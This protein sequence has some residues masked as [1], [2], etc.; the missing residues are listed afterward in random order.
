MPPLP[1]AV[2]LLVLGVALAFVTDPLD[3]EWLDTLVALQ[4]VVSALVTAVLLTVW[5]VRRLRQGFQAASAAKLQ[6]SAARAER[7]RPTPYRFNPPPAWPTPAPHWVPAP[8]WEPER[9]WP[10]IPRGWQLWERTSPRPAPPQRLSAWDP[11]PAAERLVD[12]H[13]QPDK[14]RNALNSDGGR[15]SLQIGAMQLQ[16]GGL[17]QRIHIDIEH[18]PGG[19][20]AAERSRWHPLEWAYRH[21]CDAVVGIAGAL[22]DELSAANE[23]DSTVMVG[24]EHI[25]RWQHLYSWMDEALDAAA[26]RAGVSRDDP[27]LRNATGAAPSERLSVSVDVGATGWQEAERLAASALRQFGFSDADVT[28]AGTDRGLDVSGSSIAAQVKYTSASVGRPLIQQLTGAAGGRQTAFF[29]RSGYT[30]HAVE[31][32]ERHAMALFT[33]TLPTSVTAHNSAARQMI[34][35]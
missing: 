5:M 2:A 10:P 29:S 34:S 6:A 31:E 27:R 13:F 1:A 3:W 19:R 26:E 33:L 24:E 9:S 4:I 32:A 11:D 23:P 8:G 22:N 35:R 16:L 20:Q 21:A 7:F 25:K 17:E 15:R 28:G 14:I 12:V 30:Q 18:Q